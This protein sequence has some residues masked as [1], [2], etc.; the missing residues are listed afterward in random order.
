MCV[1]LGTKHAI[2]MR[3]IVICELHYNFFF[4]WSHERQ[5]FEKKKLLSK[6]CVFR[7]SL[8]L[9]SETFLINS[10]NA[11]LN[12]IWHLLALLRAHHI[13]HVRRIRVKEEIGEIWWN[14]YIG[15]HVEYLLFLSDF[16]ETWIFHTG[17]ETYLHIKF[18]ENVSSESLV[19][20]CGRIDG[21]A[22]R[23]RHGEVSSLF[24]QFCE[25]A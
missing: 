1:D 9:L 7:V 11:E 2:R 6:I 18:Y 3:H 19:V 23:H 12:P 22:D 13:F 5:F 20:A 14:I 25:R 17:F 8:Q 21:Q 4:S 16:H 24:S 15:L 10:L